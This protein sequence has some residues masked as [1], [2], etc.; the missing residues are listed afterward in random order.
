MLSFEDGENR[1][2]RIC[3]LG[4]DARG[5]LDDFFLVSLG[6]DQVPRGEYAISD[7]L[8]EEQW[9]TPSFVKWG[10]LRFVPRTPEAAQWFARTGKHG[11]AVHGRDFFPLAA[12]MTDHPKMVRFISDRLFEQLEAGWGALRISNW[13]MGRLYDYYE[14][15]VTAPAEWKVRVTAGSLEEITTVCEPLKVQRKPG[16]PLE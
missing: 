14:R 4:M 16:G 10:A 7:A 6:R 11:L 1:L 12:R 13:D 3:F 2:E 15:F 5:N 8:P 9:P